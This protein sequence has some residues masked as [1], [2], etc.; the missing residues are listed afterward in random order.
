MWTRL[1]IGGLAPKLPLA[2]HVRPPLSEAQ[3]PLLQ[4]HKAL[5]RPSSAGRPWIW[6][7]PRSPP[8]WGVPDRARFTSTHAMG[9]RFLS[10]SWN[11][12]PRSK[13]T[14]G[15][16]TGFGSPLLA[17]VFKSVSG[18]LD[19]AEPRRRRSRVSAGHLYESCLKR[20]RAVAS[21]CEVSFL[22]ASRWRLPSQAGQ[23]HRL[24]GFWLLSHR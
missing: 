24:Q 1:R 19:Q 9:R 17:H 8:R 15:S 21:Y 22:P 5:A 6:A 14:M 3:P 12:R 16:L 23:Q 10:L 7:T 4:T 18:H 13:L 11:E 2:P 20:L